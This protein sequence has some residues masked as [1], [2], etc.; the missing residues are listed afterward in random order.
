MATNNQPI[1]LSD[2][3]SLYSGDVITLNNSNPLLVEVLDNQSIKLRKFDK[4]EYLSKRNFIERKVRK[5]LDFSASF[6]ESLTFTIK[7]N[8]NSQISLQTADKYLD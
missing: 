1:K 5:S 3:L 8:N 7:S 6:E 4:N 2:Q